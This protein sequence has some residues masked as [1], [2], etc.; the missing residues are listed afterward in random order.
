MKK[1]FK[2]VCCSILFWPISFFL[3]GVMWGV[4][5]APNLYNCTDDGP[6]GIWGFVFPG[7]GWP[8]GYYRV[9][10]V[11]HIV[12]DMDMSHPDTIKAG[13]TMTG[14]WV[15]WSAFVTGSLLSALLVAI[16]MCGENSFRRIFET[17]T[18]T[19]IE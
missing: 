9:V 14:I 6:T 5:V 2:V 15:L 3:F 7:M 17:I 12:P 4:F 13:W 8:H 16:W 19:R 10:Q 1:L 18:M 11:K